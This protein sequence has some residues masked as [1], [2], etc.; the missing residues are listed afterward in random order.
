MGETH[1]SIVY[2]WSVSTV[3]NLKFHNFY[4]FDKSCAQGL[5]SMP[6][7]EIKYMLDN[8]TISLGLGHLGQE[9][10]LRPQIVAG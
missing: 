8:F 1:R 2:L 7:K 6:E 3:H 9:L 5:P 4:N 10:C